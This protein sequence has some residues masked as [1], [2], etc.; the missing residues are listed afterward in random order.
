MRTRFVVAASLLVASAAIVFELSSC[1]GSKRHPRPQF[2][3]LD[4][5]RFVVDGKPFRFVGANV[6]VLYRDEDR[7]R[8]PETLKRSAEIGIRVI[9]VWASGEGGPHDVQPIADFADW[10]RTHYFRLKPGDWNEAEFVFLDRI[11]AEA[12]QNGLR[13]QVCLANWWRDTGGVTQYL[14]WAGINGADDDKYPF[15]INNEKAMQ[16]YTNE[17]ARRLY[18]EHVEKIAARRNS[19]TGVYYRDDPT[20]FGY[21]LMNEAQCI[22]GRWSERRQWLAEMSAYLKSLDPNHL[23]APGEWG[24]RS[25]AERREWSLDHNLPNIDY[26][27]LHSYPKDDKDSFV[28][29]P[30]ALDEF[31]QN[32]VAAACAIKRPLVL[33]EFGMSV[34]GYN[35]H[36]QLE[37][38][39]GYFENAAR[40]GVAGAMFWILTPDPAR[41]YGVTYATPRD[42]ALLAEITGGAH[43]FSS[44]INASP[45]PNLLDAG[46]HLVPRQFAFG[47]DEHSSTVQPH[48]ISQPGGRILYRFWPNMVVRGRFEKIGGGEGYIWGAGVGFFEF[49]VPERNDHRRVEQI[50][51]RAHLHPVAPIDADLAWVHT[52]VTLFVN[53]EDCGSRLVAVEDPERPLIQEWKIDSWRPRLRAARGLPFTIRFAVTLQS[54]WL[55]GINISNWSKTYDAHGA[56]PVEIEIN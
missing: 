34:N 18:R 51:V 40:E 45:P 30:K 15:G 44:L 55:Y 47:E 35:G 46:K 21:E 7:A 50:V 26:C 4:G 27:D 33:G 28:D 54:D 56:S 53:G 48:V 17:T 20:I 41:G 25:A 9:R 5:T 13:V 3:S 36:S 19:I 16:F 52:R 29:S 12:A 37:W 6:A 43:L 8:M 1:G 10:P 2:V 22:T 23:I 42:A 39:R 14:R 38:F 11:L 31:I 49:V 32:R 24:Y